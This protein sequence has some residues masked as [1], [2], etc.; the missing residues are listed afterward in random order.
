MVRVIL[1]LH[2]KRD[3][4]RWLTGVLSTWLTLRQIEC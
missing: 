3:V 2:L 4:L 1:G